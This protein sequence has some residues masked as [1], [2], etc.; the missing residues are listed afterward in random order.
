[1]KK[2]RVRLDRALSKLG[3]ASRAA[4]RALILEG[5]VTVGGRVVRDPAIE[6]VPE[7]GDIVVD[8]RRARRPPWRTILLHKPRGV[9]TTRRDPEGRPTV[10]DLLGPEAAGLV[11]VGRLDLATSGLLLL[12]SD[13]RLADRLTDPAN[14]VVRRYAVTVRGELSDAAAQRMETGLDGLRAQSV[15]IRKRS[16]RETHLIVE[17]TEGQNREIR[18][19]C[20]AVGFEV[21]KLHRVGFGSLA[22]G[23]LPPGRWREVTRDELDHRASERR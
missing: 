13:T 9:V 1:V 14:A 8:G 4:G 17:L 22:L 18:R 6:V 7:R 11:A 12:T 5:K 3:V 10:F 23:D 15:T 16:G 21:T 20:A 2:G 19:L